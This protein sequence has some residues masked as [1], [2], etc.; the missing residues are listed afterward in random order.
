MALFIKSVIF[1]QPSVFFSS[2]LKIEM[3]YI[4]LTIF[5]FL[6]CAAFAQQITYQP[7]HGTT[8]T[9]V[10]HHQVADGSGGVYEWYTRSVWSGDTLINNQNYTRMFGAGNGLDPNV[11]MSGGSFFRENL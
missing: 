5:S 2:R 8:S 10:Y 3:R 7:W 1:F 11:Q 9:W 6:F 4:F